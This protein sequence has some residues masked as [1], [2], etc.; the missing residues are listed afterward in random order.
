MLRLTLNTF[1]LKSQHIFLLAIKYN[2]KTTLPFLTSFSLNSYIRILSYNLLQLF[3]NQNNVKP[4]TKD[5]L[6]SDAH[7][8]SYW[9][10]SNAQNSTTKMWQRQQIKLYAAAA[11]NSQCF[12]NYVIKS[13]RST[14]IMFALSLRNKN[15]I[16]RSVYKNGSIAFTVGL[17][18]IL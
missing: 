1:V 15:F 2:L 13:N 6:L 12:L 11:E 18:L 17:L 7:G 8:C 9:S 3:Y 4:K 5:K 10:H 16:E 14:F